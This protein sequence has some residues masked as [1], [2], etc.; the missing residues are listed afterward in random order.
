MI[1]ENKRS[2]A[3]RCSELSTSS[4]DIEMKKLVIQRRSATRPG[5]A[6]NFKLNLHNILVSAAFSEVA[7]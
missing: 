5:Q 2:G 3:L 1:A 6:V 7:A 4:K